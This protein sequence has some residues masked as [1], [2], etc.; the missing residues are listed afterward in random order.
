MGG[1]AAFLD[2]SN[3][4]ELEFGCERPMSIAS[5]G[6]ADIELSAAKNFGAK[7]ARKDALGICEK[8]QATKESALARRCR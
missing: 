3:S 8:E 5:C 4:K 7:A 2:Y 6:L 1:S